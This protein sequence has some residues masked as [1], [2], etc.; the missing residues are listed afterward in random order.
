MPHP[1]WIDP[2][3][4]FHVVLEAIGAPGPVVLRSTPD[5]DP[6][7]TAFYDEWERLTHEHVAGHLLLICHGDEARTLL[8]EALA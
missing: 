5:A 4:R 7:M 6:A 8:R 3:A 2:V 1:E